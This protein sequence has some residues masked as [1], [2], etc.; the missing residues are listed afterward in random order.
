VQTVGH[1]DQHHPYVGGHGKQELS[2]IL[3]L[4][5]GLVPED[6]AG[7]L[8][9]PLHDGGYLGAEDGLD[10]L[11]R[12]VGVFHHVMEECG[13]YRSRAEAEFGYDDFCH[14]DGMEYV[15]LPAAAAYALVG[16]LGKPVGLLD[17]LHLLAV[18]A[19]QIGL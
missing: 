4:D 6:A 16:L 2:E 7:D 11:F 15:R 14:G 18:V 3:G 8:G 5:R 9:Q 12:V 17:D 19:L 13:A 10:V 1:L